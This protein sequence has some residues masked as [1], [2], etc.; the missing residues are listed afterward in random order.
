MFIKVTDAGVLSYTIDQL[1]SDNPDVSFP[2]TIPDEVL[3]TFNVYRYTT[4]DIPV[5]D[6]RVTFLKEVYVNELGSWYLDWELVSY[7]EADIIMY[8]NNMVQKVKIEAQRRILALV[9]DWKQ[10]NIAARMAELS[11]I[12]QPNWTVSQASEYQ[13][14]VNVWASIDNIR[15]L[16]DTLEAMSPIPKDYTDDRYWQ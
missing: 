7:T 2:S 5:Y 15:Q 14:Y 12:G 16:S 9:P 10:R 11:V 13:T 8:D 1:K 6:D 4:K 3:A